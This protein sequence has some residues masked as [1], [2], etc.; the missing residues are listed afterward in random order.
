MSNMT[1][2]SIKDINQGIKDLIEGEQS[3]QNVW[4]K[5]ELSNFTHH[6]SGHM[7]YSLK[8]K[9]GVLRCVMF[10]GY[11]AS[12]DF[13]PSNGTKVMARGDISVYERSGQYQVIVKQM[14]P[15]GLG[16][17]HLAYQELKKK[18]E[19]EGL[20]ERDLKKP[21]PKHPKSIGVVTSGTG[22]AVHDIISTIKRRYPIAKIILMPVSVQGDYAKKSICQAIKTLDQHKGVDVIIAGRGGGSIEELWAFNEEDVAR[23]IFHCQTPI[24]SAV[25]HET[26]FTIAD[27][28]SDLRAPTPTGAAE[29]VTPYPIHDLTVRVEQLKNM[30]KRELLNKYESRKDKLDRLKRNLDY[31]HPA[32]QMREIMQ[33]VDMLSSR[34]ER[35][36]DVLLKEKRS[37][38]SHLIDK[39][40]TLSP[41]KTMNRGFSIVKK[42]E[43]VLKSVKD[44]SEGETITVNVSDGEMDCH[45]DKIRSGHDE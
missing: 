29:Y 33:H 16:N 44:V 3:L 40:D 18:L 8:D 32:K 35:A 45:I 15:D 1:I 22:A 34:M 38:L 30:M 41:L 25:G 13:K 20:F 21:I 6:A 24:V 26:D 27:F 19:Q 23:A 31:R 9:S 14:L 17:L 5:G 28:V 43:R 4:I 42:E 37:H 10:K 11:N 12:L 7:Y 39:L 2:L 36:T